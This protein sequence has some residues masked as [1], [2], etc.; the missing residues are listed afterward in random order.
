MTWLS[1]IVF[2]VFIGA[3]A[4]PDWVKSGVEFDTDGSGVNNANL[5]RARV[6]V[7][8]ERPSRGFRWSK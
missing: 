3:V 4:G 5:V 2:C 7:Q 1:F 8:G 6:G